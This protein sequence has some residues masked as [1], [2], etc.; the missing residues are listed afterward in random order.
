M[1]G[2]RSLLLSVCPWEGP[3]DPR[4]PY[5]VRQGSKKLEICLLMCVFNA[6]D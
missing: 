1:H 6:A 4:S 2:G 5:L 3:R